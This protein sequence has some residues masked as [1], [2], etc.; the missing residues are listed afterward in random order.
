MLESS[1]DIVSRTYKL[2]ARFAKVNEG[3]KEY[4]SGLGRDFGRITIHC[5]LPGR[6]LEEVS[7]DLMIALKCGRT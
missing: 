1:E 2:K 7:F 5:Q 3:C 6:C 4:G